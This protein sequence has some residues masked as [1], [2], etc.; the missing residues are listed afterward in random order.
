[1]KIKAFLGDNVHLK[2]SAIVE[3]G[4]HHKKQ[5]TLKYVQT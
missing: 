4:S 1:M 3:N 5:T 2:T